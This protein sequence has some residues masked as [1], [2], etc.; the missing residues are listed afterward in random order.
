M[1]G[2]WR[3]HG[4]ALDKTGEIELRVFELITSIARASRYARRTMRVHDASMSK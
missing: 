2:R 1:T 4:A 3:P